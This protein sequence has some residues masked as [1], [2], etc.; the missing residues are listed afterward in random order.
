[1]FLGL[2]PSRLKLIQLC[3]DHE[4]NGVEREG[5]GCQESSWRMLGLWRHGGRV[6]LGG[7]ISVLLSGLFIVRH[8]G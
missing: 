1:M 6:G 3:V 2:Y 8:E 4:M 7:S 5:R